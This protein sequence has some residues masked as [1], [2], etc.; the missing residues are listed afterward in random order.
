MASWPGD[1]AKMRAHSDLLPHS[2]P[3]HPWLVLFAP[4]PVGDGT[5]WRAGTESPWGNCQRPTLQVLPLIFMMISLMPPGSR[6]IIKL[7]G[8]SELLCEF[9]IVWKHTQSSR[10]RDLGTLGCCGSPPS[11]RSELWLEAPGR[12]GGQHCCS[13][14]GPVTP[15]LPAAALDRSP[16]SFCLMRAI[17]VSVVS[18]VS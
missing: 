10:P 6:S 12:W 14:A 7:P 18:T 16:G 17:S 15:L 13:P 4:V 11:P 3:V 8:P 5:G 2:L 1:R 9:L